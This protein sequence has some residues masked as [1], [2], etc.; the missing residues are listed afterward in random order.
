[1]FSKANHSERIY[2]GIIQQNADDDVDCLQGYCELMGTP[3]TDAQ[4]A[5]NDPGDCTLFKQ[6]RMVRMKVQF[7][8]FDINF[9]PHSSL[10][11]TNTGTTALCLRGLHHALLDASC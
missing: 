11:S 5:N 2:F 6:V 9:D 10:A 4:I 7:N 8:D 3:V 1:M